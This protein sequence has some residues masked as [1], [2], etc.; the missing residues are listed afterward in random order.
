LAVAKKFNIVVSN[1]LN[2]ESTELTQETQFDPEDNLKIRELENIS[3]EES[4]DAHPFN[5]KELSSL[6][7]SFYSQIICGMLRTILRMALRIRLKKIAKRN[8]N[9]FLILKNYY[10]RKQKIMR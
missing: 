3:T 4:L 7:T 5:I 1:N 2:S 8:K 9:L 6:I 10:Y